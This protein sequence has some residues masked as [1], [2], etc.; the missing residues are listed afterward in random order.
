MRRKHVPMRTCAGCGAKADKRQLIRIVHS[1]TG[2][3]EVDDTGKKA[4]R[5]AYLCTR[6][7]CWEHGIT[8]ERLDYALH[9]SIPPGER[10]ALLAY[11]QRWHLAAPVAQGGIQPG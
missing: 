5:G 9:M 1:P 3:V 7:S 8:K 6:L 2:T 4:G 11:A 10:E